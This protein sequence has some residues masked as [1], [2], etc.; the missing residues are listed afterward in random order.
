M[1]LRDASAGYGVDL[2]SLEQLQEGRLL[3]R[4]P[5]LADWVPRLEAQGQRG[6]A[7]VSEAASRSSAAVTVPV[8]GG[9]TSGCWV[10]TASLLRETVRECSEHH[11][12]RVT[13]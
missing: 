13:F 5:F 10:M 8:G 12:R 6:V 2:E 1:H 9:L 4:L 11:K 7:L 3:L